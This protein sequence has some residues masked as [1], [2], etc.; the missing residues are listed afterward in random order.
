M[1]EGFCEC[2]C[3]WRTRIAAR[4]DSR[5]GWIKGEPLRFILG[6]NMR[7]KKHSPESRAKISVASSG[8]KTS[9][10]TRAKMSAASSGPLGSNWRGGRW[11]MADGY[12]YVWLPADHPFAAMCNARGYVGEHRLVL[13]KNLGRPLTG[14]EVAHHRNGVRDDNRIKN[15]GLFPSNA[16][17]VSYHR[18]LRRA[19]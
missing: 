19:A 15:L 8:H 3:G 11:K 6:H 10:E 4:T 5:F 18:K 12:I 9:P 2:G 16:S 7:G 1:S 13:A 14:E 17:H